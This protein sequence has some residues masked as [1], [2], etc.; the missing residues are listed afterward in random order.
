M[1]EHRRRSRPY[2]QSHPRVSRSKKPEWLR[3]ITNLS[4]DDYLRVLANAACA[5]GNSSSFVRD[6][7][8]F[9]TPIVLLG[10][11]Q[12][13]RETDVHVTPAPPLTPNVVA[14]IKAQLNHGRYAPSTLYGDG[15]VSQRIA[16]ALV[17]LQPYVQKRLHYIHENAEVTA[18]R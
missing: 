7:G 2:Q 15:Y 5:I 8:Y 9:V 16:N 10:N 3:T 13:G 6:A 11:R 17:R 1:A 18:V 12:E 14:A 4:P